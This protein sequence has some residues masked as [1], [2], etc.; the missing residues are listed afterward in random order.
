M[1]QDQSRTGQETNQINAI[2]KEF[3]NQSFENENKSKHRQC[4]E[5]VLPSNYNMGIPSHNNGIFLSIKE[6]R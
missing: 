5:T 1:I 3:S 2:D 6:K 4:Q